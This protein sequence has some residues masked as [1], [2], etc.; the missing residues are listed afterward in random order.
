[1]NNQLD[2]YFLGGEV[3]GEITSGVPS[4]SLGVNVSMG[5]VDRAFVKK[6]TAVQFEIRKKRVDAEVVKMP[7]VPAKYYIKK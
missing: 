4:P 3:I 5:Y 1:M 6:G 2:F 7:F